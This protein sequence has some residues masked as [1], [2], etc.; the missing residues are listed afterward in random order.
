MNL[1]ETNGQDR[2]LDTAR[3]PS[4]ALEIIVHLAVA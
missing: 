4:D 2:V 1:R 3:L